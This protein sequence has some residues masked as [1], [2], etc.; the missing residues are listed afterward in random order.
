MSAKAPSNSRNHL[1]FHIPESIESSIPLGSTKPRGNK[2]LVDPS[3][4]IAQLTPESRQCLYRLAS[5]RPQKP[6]VTVPRSRR[7]AVL[8]ALFI[9]RSGDLYV[10]LSRRS[11]SLRT[12]AGDTSL[13]GGKV[14]KGDKS[15]EHTARREAF[16][17]IGLPRDRRKVPLLCILEPVL[18]AELV[19]TPVVVLVLDTTLRPILNAHEVAS[20]F[21]HPL[22]SFLSV[23][24]PFN[25]SEPETVEVDYHKSFNVEWSA[26]HGQKYPYRVHQFLTGREAGGIK[27]IFGLTA[28]MMIRVATIGYGR[29]PDFEVITPGAPSL[30]ERIAWALLSRPVFRHA[31]EKEGVDLALPMKICGVTRAELDALKKGQDGQDENGGGGQGKQGVSEVARRRNWLRAWRAKL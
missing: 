7:A 1:K 15:I 28:G 11:A 9:G 23:T 31:C 17:E 14:D 2:L 5:Y 24:S 30:D 8:V 12:Y 25:A 4:R 13:P 26:P 20:L 6:T 19:V 27:P 22:A 10:L 21:S 18:A 29:Q 3:S 16:E